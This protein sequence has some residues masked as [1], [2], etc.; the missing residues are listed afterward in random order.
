[1]KKKI[2]RS[3]MKGVPIDS[4]DLIRNCLKD[5]GTKHRI[6]FRGPRNLPQDTRKAFT[7]QAGCLKEHATHF[8]VYPKR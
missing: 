5:S 1:M 4:L 8:A 3:I 2:A 7:R 6:V